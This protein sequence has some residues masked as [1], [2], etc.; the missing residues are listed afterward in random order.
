MTTKIITVEL[1]ESEATIIVSALRR[2]VRYLTMG[3]FR[4]QAEKARSL[5]DHFSELVAMCRG[6]G[7]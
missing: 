7:H 3:G 5:A 4:Q 6:S 1:T 2:K